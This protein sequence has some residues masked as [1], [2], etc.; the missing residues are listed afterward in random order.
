MPRRGAS[1]TPASRRS[2]I[3]K[4]TSWC[5]TVAEHPRAVDDGYGVALK[6]QQARLRGE[7][8]ARPSQRSVGEREVGSLRRIVPGLEPALADRE[9]RFACSRDTQPFARTAIGGWAS[10]CASK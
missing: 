8:I 1:M 10:N 5:I 6:R 3:R 2:R 4:Y 7:Q 9:E